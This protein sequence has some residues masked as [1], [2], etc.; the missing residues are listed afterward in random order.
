MDGSKRIQN[1][2][3]QQ[4]KIG[5]SKSKFQRWKIQWMELTVGQTLHTKKISG[6]ENMAI[7]AIQNE[8]VREKPKTKVNSYGAA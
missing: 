5:K 2:K 8:T 6:F 3:K 4:W 1:I 7:E